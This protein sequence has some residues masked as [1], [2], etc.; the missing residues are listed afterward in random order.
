MAM[1]ENEQR[2]RHK[3]N[4]RVT[5]FGLVESILGMCFALAAVLV[6]IG[7]AVYLAKNGQTAV[8]LALIGVVGTLAAIFYLK[9]NPTGSK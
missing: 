6:C 2:Y 3:I 4:N 1:A 9:K 8:S 5:S 7:A